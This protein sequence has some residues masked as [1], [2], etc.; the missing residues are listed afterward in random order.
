MGFTI[1]V[2]VKQVPDTKNITGE[3]MRPDGTVN[4]D[5]LPAIFNPEDLNGLEEALRIK[6]RFGGTITALSMGPPKA[7]EVLKE[8]LYRGADRAV[9]V[10]DRGF[11]GSDTLATSYALSCAIKRIE[12][13]DLIV[14]GRQAI[15]GD[16]AQVGPQVAE[17]LGINQLTN[18]SAILEVS[19]ERV[20]VKRSIENGYQQ[21]AA[22]PP[23]L[24]SV[25]AEANEP[26]SPSAKRVMGYKKIRT[27]KEEIG[28]DTWPDGP[29]DHIKLWDMGSIQADQDLC[30]FS[31]SA[32]WVKKIE[33]VVLTARET[34]QIENSEQ[35]I[36]GLIRELIDEHII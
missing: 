11:S 36:S 18:V 8:C 25:T 24:L 2:L 21:L 19:G 4:R 12:D 20:V 5:V 16:T 34:K 33:N 28:S 23:L 29:V 22:K 30:G 17:K 1:V 32:T 13:I 10:S 6:E 7:V 3:A 26:R 35:G 27:R 15:D 31:G 14:C 9:L